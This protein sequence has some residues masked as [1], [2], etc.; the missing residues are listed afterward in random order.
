MREKYG[1]AEWQSRYGLK[2]MIRKANPSKESIVT[3]CTIRRMA[4]LGVVGLA[5]SALT[6]TALSSVSTAQA[7]SVARVQGSSRPAATKSAPLVAMVQ[8]LTD[9]FTSAA[10]RGA[11]LE[12]AKYGW[13]VY[14]T[15]PGEI[16]TT[17]QIADVDAA[18]TKGVSGIMLE[19][20]DATALE[21]AVN[22]AAAHN[23]PV[24][25]YAT[26][27]NQTKGTIGT[28]NANPSS[29]AFTAG[30][31]MCPKIHDS[32]VVLI[33][34]AVEGNPNLTERWV[35]FRAGI[36]AKCP[37]VKIVSEITQ[38]LEA[39]AATDTTALLSK[40]PT[41]KGIF[42]DSL[43]DGMG[44]VSGVASGHET[45]KVYIESFDA[46]PAEVTALLKGQ[47]G[48]LVA[49]K[50]YEEGELGIIDL[51]KHAHGQKVP[52]YYNVGTVIMTKANYA[53]TKI[54]AY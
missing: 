41:L 1:E 35:G 16:N 8:E 17:E 22:L 46:E 40:Y 12:A 52:S 53:T 18:V 19:P 2:C 13:K 30:E 11:Q 34:E 5:T 31:D 29:G 48:L 27:L 28:E 6:L 15:G 21:P 44:A 25:I 47:I 39:T 32:G 54:W 10:L 43:M 3:N 33:L 49:Q 50:P 26:T 4:R 7:R 38:N 9:P 51:W 36:K 37:G 14:L 42:S 45:G 24:V 23:I 20:S